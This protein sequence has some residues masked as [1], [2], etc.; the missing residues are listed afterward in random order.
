MESFLLEFFLSW[1]SLSFSIFLHPETFTA[2]AHFLQMDGFDDGEENLH[3]WR[4]RWK[5]DEKDIPFLLLS[6]KGGRMKTGL[7]AN[8][9][10][11]AR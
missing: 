1:F 5:K 6:R 9:N 3:F 4:P 7:V 8:Q 10:V 11:V 2:G